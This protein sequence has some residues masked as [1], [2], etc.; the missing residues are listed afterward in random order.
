M[1][2]IK[3]DYT[4]HANKLQYAEQLLD[5]AKADFRNKNSRIKAL[6]AHLDESRNEISRLTRLLQRGAWK[7]PRGTQARLWIMLWAVKDKTCTDLTPAKQGRVTC[8]WTDTW[9]K[10]GGDGVETFTSALWRTL[11]HNKS[12]RICCSQ[13]QIIAWLGPK[14]P[15]Q[16]HQEHWQIQPQRAKCNSKMQ[17]QNVQAYLQDIDFHL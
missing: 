16:A 9:A 12:K 10:Y 17:L 2:Q 8:S 3:E 5:K 14:R 1:E 4:D 13:P 7:F 15:R 6:E 11:P